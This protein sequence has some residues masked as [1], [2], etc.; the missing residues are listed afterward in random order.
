VPCVLCPSAIN[1]AS[2]CASLLAREPCG[3]RGLKS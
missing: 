3:R 2:D 1:R